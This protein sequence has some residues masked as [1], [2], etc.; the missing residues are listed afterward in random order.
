MNESY[1]CDT[2]QMYL[3][4]GNSLQ[5][6]L[7]KIKDIED[8]LNTE[9]IDREKMSKT[10]NKDIAVLDYGNRNQEEWKTQSKTQN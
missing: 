5:F 10:L 7:S 9:I 4:L 6:R 3:Q 8:F 2:K 1:A